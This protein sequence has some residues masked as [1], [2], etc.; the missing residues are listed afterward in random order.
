MHVRRTWCCCGPAAARRSAAVAAN[1]LVQVASTQPRSTHGARALAHEVLFF[2][3]LWLPTIKGPAS[4]TALNALVLHQSSMLRATD[5]RPLHETRAKCAF[6]LL[7]FRE[8]TE[9]FGASLALAL[10]GS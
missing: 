6:P 4:P 5:V 7:I 10:H 3:L 8:C 1:V 9:V 2:A